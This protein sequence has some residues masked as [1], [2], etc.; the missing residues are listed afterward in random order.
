MKKIYECSSAASS[1]VG[2]MTLVSL[3]VIM[4]AAIG[5][6][7]LA[8]ALPVSTPQNIAAP[9][10]RITAAEAKGGLSAS[11]DENIIKLKHKG[12][13]SLDLK[14][15]R[16]II[17]GIGR[18]YR[19]IF[20]GGYVP[21]LPNTGN[22]QV[23]YN[24]LTRFGKY[25]DYYSA[26]GPVLQDGYWSTGETLVLSGEDSINSDDRRSSVIVTVNGDGDTSNNYKFKASEKIYITVI[27][28]NTNEIISSSFIDI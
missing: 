21:P 4:V 27:D 17:N 19:S 20:G 8:F 12:G 24:N 15:T 13:D 10:A 3:S 7:L 28:R 18:S 2:V 9:Q 25:A 5:T 23:I 16:I 1:V 26:N 6:S 11:F 22:V 14:E